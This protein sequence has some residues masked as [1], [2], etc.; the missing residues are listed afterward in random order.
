[1]GAAA[2]HRQRGAALL[3]L[4]LVLAIGGTWYLVSRMQ[5][6]SANTTAAL[7][8]RNAEVLNKA[9][10]AL[11]GYVVAQANH[12]GENNPGSLPCPEA[13]GSF[14]ATNGTDGKMNSA[15]CALPA[16]GRYPWRTIGTDKFVDA[17]G[18][19]L[20]YVVSPGWAVT[21]IGCTT[22]INS[23]SVGQLNIDGV[24]YASLPPGDTVVAL[25][26]APGPAFSA[27]AAA[28]CG[29][30]N[31]TRPATSGLAPDVRNY[32]ECENATNPADANFVTSGPSG[33][34]NDQVVKVTVADIMP[35]L[36]AAV[37][38][39][40]QR[41]SEFFDTLKTV[42]SAATGWGLT[43]SSVL[44]PFAAPF[45]DPSTSAMQGASA[46]YAGLLP[47]NYAETSPGSGVACTPSAGAPRCAPSFVGWSGTPTLSG[48]GIYSPDCGATVPTQVNCTFYIRC[49]LLSC[50]L[51]TGSDTLAFS[52]NAT[53]AKTGMALRQ[54]NP[55]TP[56]TNVDVA[57]RTASGVMNA[58]GSAAITLT[59][60][61]TV[62]YNSGLLM[63]LLG[64]VL[65]SLSGLLLLT[66]GCQQAA[67][68][69]P[70]LLL[71]DHPVLD[72]T[73]STYGW[74]LRNKWHELTY[75]A[76]A[77][78]YTPAVRPG[79]PSC[80]T[81]STCLSVSNVAPSGAQRAIAILTGRS[82][83]GTS[84][85][86]STLADYLEFGNA[87]ASYETQGV[88]DSVRYVLADSG[89]A[90]AYAVS[91]SSVG[92]GQSITFRASNA[93]TGASTLNTPATGVKTLVNADGSGLSAAQIRANAAVQVTY[94]GSQFVLY[95]KRPFNDRVVVIDS[96]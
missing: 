87:G 72:A 32:L 44:Y 41:T 68:A 34:F 24:A 8:A 47:V 17:S 79:Q 7:R 15:G 58:D 18:E 96:N 95:A 25:I 70:I 46:T 71:A 33:S 20:W 13:P 4:L 28:G 52:L 90:N 2:R 36:E 22:V 9:K 42:Y 74:Y 40:L 3:V 80:V 59:G 35:G 63:G 16:V 75:Y 85:P 27:P 23:N 55:A 93:N 67:I 88:R 11:I 51:S 92:V 53:A 38:D 50:G 12:A 5:Q 73:N 76:V 45:S 94:D 31:Q 62:A 61:T 1:M 82:I 43:G 81:G 54:L 83:N 14:N 77:T 84:R 21:C 37:A 29:A 65:C 89:A 64:G 49:P 39:R 66:T 6:L 91:V 78:N 48:P 30:W 26:I 86:S 60:T 57:G 10:Q 19:P 56:M 69:V